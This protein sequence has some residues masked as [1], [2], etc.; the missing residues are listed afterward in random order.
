MEMNMSRQLRCFRLFTDPY[1]IFYTF[2]IEDA[3][4]V[5]VS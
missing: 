2:D 3:S 1:E 5:N 4:C